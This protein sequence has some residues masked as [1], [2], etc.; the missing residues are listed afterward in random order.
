MPIS[1][2]FHTHTI[3]VDCFNQNNWKL[4]SSMVSQKDEYISKGLYFEAAHE[5]QSS[6]RLKSFF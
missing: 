6:T 5:C 3:N 1:F 2:I 4:F